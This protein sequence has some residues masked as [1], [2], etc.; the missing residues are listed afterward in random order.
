MRLRAAEVFTAMQ[1]RVTEALRSIDPSVSYVEDLWDRDGHG[2]EGGGGRTRVFSDGEIIE[3]A[4]VNFSNVEGV[5]SPALAKTIL[6]E[7][8]EAPFI[9]TGTS[10]IIHPRSPMVPTIH[11]NVRYFEVKDQS[12]FGGGID[13]TPYYLF[14]DDCRH[15]HATLRAVCNRHD[16]TYY[17]R[18]KKWCDEYFFL[19]HR[20]EARGI[21]GLFFDH[22]G[23]EGAPAEHYFSFVADVARSFNELYFPIVER[24]KNEPWSEAEKNFQLMRRG[25]YVEFNLL[26]DRGTQFGLKSMGRTESILVSMPPCATWCYDYRPIAG[27][28]EEQLLEVLRH[29]RVW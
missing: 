28:R 9:A 29:P 23:R 10:L 6:A 5:L 15:F 14:E 12:W 11:A 25:R 17:P 2:Q 22:L 26:Y 20:S 7:E 18:F 3:R 27:S 24:R 21:G 1:E 4:G 16:T 13:L 8:K 19:P